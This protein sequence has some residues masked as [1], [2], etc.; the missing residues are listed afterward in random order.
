ME[1]FLKSICLFHVSKLYHTQNLH[2]SG[3]PTI[4]V[5]GD[6]IKGTISISVGG[7]GLLSLI[8]GWFASELVRYFLNKTGLYLL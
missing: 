8:Y 3:N 4:S 7:K 5:F 1:L 2:P 6:T